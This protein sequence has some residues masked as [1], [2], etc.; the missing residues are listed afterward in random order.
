MALIFAK[1]PQ[2][3]YLANNPVIFH[4]MSGSTEPVQMECSPVGFSNLLNPA[5]FSLNK[6][7]AVTPPL[8]TGELVDDP[9]YDTTDFLYYEPGV[10][11]KWWSADGPFTAQ[12]MH[13]VYDADKNFYGGWDESTIGSDNT[14][15]VSVPTYERISFRQ[16]NPG[17]S[18]VNYG[19]FVFEDEDPVWA[20]YGNR[21][22]GIYIPTGISPK[23]TVAINISDIV[24]P[25]VIPIKKESKVASRPFFF[26]CNFNYLNTAVKFRQGT[27]VLEYSCKVYNGGISKRF[28]RYLQEKGTDIFT[29]KLQNAYKQ[30][31]LTTRTSGRNVTMRES[32][33]CPVYFI[34]L[35]RT[36]DIFTEDGRQIALPGMTE[37]NVYALDLEELRKYLFND[38]H[39]NIQSLFTVKINGNVIFDITIIPAANVPN[40]YV[41]EFRNSYGVPERMEVSGKKTLQ[42][43]FGEDNVYQL[44]DESVDDYIEQNDRLPIREVINAE[45]GY[46]TIEEF[47]FARDMLQSDKRYLILPDGSRQEV[48]VKSDSFSHDAHPVVP[49]SIPLEIRLV[50]LDAEYSPIPDETLPEGGLIPVSVT[51]DGNGGL[52]ADGQPSV[53]IEVAA[54]TLW[55]D[56]QKPNFFQ[57]GTAKLENGFTHVQGNDDT[58]IDSEFAVD[59]DI[60]VYASYTVVELG[61]ITKNGE[62]LSVDRWIEKYGLNLF[63]YNEL[64]NHYTMIPELKGNLIIAIYFKVSDTF[65][66]AIFPMVYIGENLISSTVSLPFGGSDIDISLYGGLSENAREVQNNAGQR[67]KI[68]P[69]LHTPPNWTKPGIPDESYNRIRSQQS[70]RDMTILCRDAFSGHTDTYGTVGSPACEFILGLESLPAIRKEDAYFASANE[71]KIL[72][73][74]IGKASGIN[75]KLHAWRDAFTGYFFIDGE[76]VTLPYVYSDNYESVHLMR[77]FDHTIEVFGK[78]PAYGNAVPY[79]IINGRYNQDGDIVNSSY[80]LAPY[81]QIDDSFPLDEA[82]DPYANYYQKRRNENG[83]LVIAE[84]SHLL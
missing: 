24:R 66:P 34:A 20:P 39:M 46:K 29:Y 74:H 36:Y 48:R 26:S 61:V 51:F 70:G 68:M 81:R 50:D 79:Q 17:Y 52:T 45:F 84:L 16:D 12:I 14:V 25:D 76:N 43:E 71:L 78:S 10:K 58:L 72:I 80:L 37:G 33:L 9:E 59:V 22:K 4:L 41:L 60:I 75:D 63:T 6:R 47:M 65:C 35:N 7:V 67:L 69:Y 1:Q 19:L 27:D 11:Y 53:T 83:C 73:D 30:F 40:R 54:G 31:L 5:G 64:L 56:I 77:G 2:A 57:P 82:N 62:V 49:G 32:E 55:K 13:A 42:P 38:Y 23:Y 18:P 44:F 28:Q 3:R 8:F 15:L 21:Y